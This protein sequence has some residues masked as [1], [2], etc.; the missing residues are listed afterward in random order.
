MVNST[1]KVRYEFAKALVIA[2]I[3]FALGLVVGLLLCG[4]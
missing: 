4:R 2:T 3:S 1:M